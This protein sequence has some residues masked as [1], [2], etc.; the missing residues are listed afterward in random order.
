MV[1]HRSCGIERPLDEESL[2]FARKQLDAM[3]HAAADEVRGEGIMLIVATRSL[4]VRYQGVESSLTIPWPEDDDFVAAFAAAHRQRYGYTHGGRALEIA[5][6]HVEVVGR[7]GDEL[8]RSDRV[9]RRMAKTRQSA[10]AF[11]DGERRSVPVYERSE[12]LAGDRIVG[13]AIVTEEISTT[14]I[15]PG[16]EAEVLS[17]G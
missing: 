14:V 15:D 16:W 7:A 8:P 9:A 5:A 3:E 12:L 17:Q 6:A 13:P 4:D 11:I 1:R 10:T 2:E